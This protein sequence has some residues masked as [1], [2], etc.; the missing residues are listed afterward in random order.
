MKHSLRINGYRFSYLWQLLWV[1]VVYF[2]SGWLGIHYA[3]MKDGYL[4]F[5]WLPSG[6]GL[7]AMICYGKTIWPAIWFGSFGAFFLHLYINDPLNALFISAIVATLLTAIQGFFAFSLYNKTIG[8]RGLES[9]QNILLFTSKVVLAPCFLSVVSLMFIFYVSGSIKFE[10]GHIVKDIMVTWG[11]G[12]LAVF[13][14][15]FVV[16]PLV[17]QWGKEFS[18]I[19]LRHQYTQ[20]EIFS[21]IAI[22]III[23][24]S[25]FVVSPAVFLLMVLGVLIALRMGVQAAT[26]F[27]FVVSLSLT[28]ATSQNIGPFHLQTIWDSYIALLMF[29]IGLGLPVQLLATETIALK[30]S[31]ANLEA[32]VALRTQELNDAN[33]KL[34]DITRTDGLTG[35]ANRR[36]LD[37]YLQLEWSRAMR[38]EA[39]ISLLMVDIDCFKEY[40][41]LYGHMAGD[42]CLKL[43]AS[44]LKN[45]AQRSTDFVARYGGE[46]FSIV[47]PN[48]NDPIAIANMFKTAIS[49]LNI[50][51]EKSCIASVVTVSIGCSTMVP[52]V[53]TY[54]EE[55]VELSD[56]ALYD[57]KN[58]GRNKI[59][60]IKVDV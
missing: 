17:L 3:P 33:R 31:Y 23:F 52:T 30:R 13:H 25:L 51:H 58:S 42:E 46:E 44:T 12:A 10:A 14:G 55:L 53:G 57:A 29:V 22:F 40:N 20:V 47:L 59:S 56:K 45:M 4:T 34:E 7:A 41:D 11:S 18:F 54:M 24:I 27:V 2:G 38:S 39:P 5:I 1:F 8:E 36:F 19:T 48:T 49:S 21:F 6:I 60:M 16:V 35:I 26:F 32:Q 28:I 50:P 9:T 37:E 15:Y 43:V